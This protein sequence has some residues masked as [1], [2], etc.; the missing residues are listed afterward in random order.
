[1]SAAQVWASVKNHNCAECR[2]F[3]API[4]DWYHVPE[5]GRVVHGLRC[6]WQRLV[7]KGTVRGTAIVG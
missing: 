3:V 5:E 4:Q 6:W 2:Q 7:R 1:M